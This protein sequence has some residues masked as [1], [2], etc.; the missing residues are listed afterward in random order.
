M[1][2]TK[3]NEVLEEM[4]IQCGSVLMAKEEEYSDGSD[5][6]IQFKQV[7][8]LRGSS[9]LEACAGM[10]AK[11]TTKLYMMIGA[12]DRGK[13]HGQDAWEEVLNDHINY[14][15]LLKAVLID[16]GSI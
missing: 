4:Q 11:H 1:T 15:T 7:A 2:P 3:F 8:A 13:V 14:L 16:E 12:E 10:M 5:R 9:Q 6:L